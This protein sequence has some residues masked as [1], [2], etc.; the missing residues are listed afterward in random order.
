MGLI[1]ITAMSTTCGK[2]TS[3]LPERQYFIFMLP[4][5]LPFKQ[6]FVRFYTV[7]CGFALPTVMKIIAFQASAYAFLNANDTDDADLYGFLCR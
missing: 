7:G 1:F 2:Q 4:Y 6:M 5:V 3:A